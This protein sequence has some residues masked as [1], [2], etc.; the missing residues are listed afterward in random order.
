MRLQDEKFQWRPAL[1]T[2]EIYLYTPICNASLQRL[3]NQI[4]LLKSTVRNCAFHVAYSAFNV[5]LRTKN[6][7]VSVETF[8]KEH[9]LS[10]VNIWYNKK[11]K[12]LSQG[13]RKRYE[14]R[15]TKVSKR[16]TFHFSTIPS[17][18]S[19]SESS[20]NE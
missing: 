15:Q 12:C 4:N 11:R 6:S 13:N 5:V 19:S 7:S 3:L 8:Y 17:S 20:R 10:C 9:V 14:E 2:L 1:L 16:P 18:S